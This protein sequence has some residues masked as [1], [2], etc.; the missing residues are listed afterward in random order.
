[1]KKLI[2]KWLESMDVVASVKWIRRA[3]VVGF[4]A[5][6]FNIGA[7]IASLGGENFIPIGWLVF[8]FIDTLLLIVF[9]VG[10][11]KRSRKA[12]TSLFMYYTAVKLGMVLLGFGNPN[13]G[14]IILSVV[15]VYV[16]L[17]GWRG[18]VSFYKLTH[19]EYPN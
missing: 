4:I 10:A 6:A 9:S 11:W 8:C 3:S 14:A 17:M 13:P 1:M 12:C 16:F 7:P 15:C 2:R 18:S 5:A 19:P